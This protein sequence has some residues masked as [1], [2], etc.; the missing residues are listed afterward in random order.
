MTGIKFIALK[1]V[2][3]DFRPYLILIV[4]S[5]FQNEKISSAAEKTAIFPISM[6]EVSFSQGL[7]K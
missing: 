4:Q 3:S 5:Q 6:N 1:S 2:E 7:L